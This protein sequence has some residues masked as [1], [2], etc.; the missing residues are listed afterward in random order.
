MIK[1]KARNSGFEDIFFVIVFMFAIAFFFIFLSKLT[2]EV[3]P[4]INEGLQSAMPDD[5][6]VNITETLDQTDASTTSYNRLFPFL[7]IGL[8]SFIF[9]TGGFIAQHPVMIIVGIILLGV[10]VLLAVVFANVY[11]TISTTDEM[12]GTT[13]KFGIMDLFMKFLPFIAIISIV[14]VALAL[15]LRRGGGGTGGL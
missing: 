13:A 3:T 4:A 11:H 8:L 6:S 7:I 12:A 15:L 5:T 2:G 1:Y 14:I 9:I 10:G